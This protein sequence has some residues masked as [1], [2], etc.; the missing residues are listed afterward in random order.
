M[1]DFSFGKSFNMMKDGVDHYFFTSTHANMVLIGIFSVR[2]K[3]SSP[4]RGLAGLQVLAC[5][6]V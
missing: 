1:G 6:G 2:P 4:L 5:P 3:V